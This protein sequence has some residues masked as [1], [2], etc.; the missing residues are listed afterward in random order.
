MAS[1]SFYNDGSSPARTDTM[2]RTTMR[3][4]GI[5][6]DGGGGGGGGGTEGSGPP[7][8]DPTNTSSVQF[9][10]DD[11]GSVLYIWSPTNLSWTQLIGP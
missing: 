11:T 6:V 3:I 5:L 1:P 7:T 8:S 9:Y 4:L 10:W 2:L